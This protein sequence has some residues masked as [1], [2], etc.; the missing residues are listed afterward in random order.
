MG[1]Q[2]NVHDEE[3]SGQPS[4]VIDRVQSVD[5]NICERRRFT[6]SEVSC[7][8]PQISCTIL[9]EIITVRLGYHKFCARWPLKMLMGAH[10]AQRMASALTFLERYHKDGD[11]FLSHIVRVTGDET[12]VPFVN[13][14]TEEHSKKWMHT[15]HQTNRNSLNKRCLS[16]RKLMATVFC[17]RKGV[18]IKEFMQQGATI[19]SEVYCETQKTALDHS[20]QKAWNA[21]IRCSAPP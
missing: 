15:L 20:E 8:F 2:A 7:E 18:L 13:A 9:Y 19:M 1:G 5:Q 3:R 10:K 4:V 12:W 17:D 16:A 11:E 21:D 14:E 6:V